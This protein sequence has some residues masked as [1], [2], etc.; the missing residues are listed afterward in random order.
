MT[1]WRVRYDELTAAFREQHAAAAAANK[2]LDK[3]KAALRALVREH[4]E[5]L[6]EPGDKSVVHGGVIVTRTE[7]EPLPP[8]LAGEFFKRVPPDV[9]AEVLR[10]WLVKAKVTASDF[11][12]TAWRLALERELVTERALDDSFGEPPAVKA[13]S[14]GLA[15]KG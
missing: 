6:F 10:P 5:V 8:L 15:D 3:T 13:W 9:F 2:A 14:V 12:D 11:D 1:D 4:E 7:D